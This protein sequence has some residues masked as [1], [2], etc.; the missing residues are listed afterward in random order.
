MTI[1]PIGRHELEVTTANG[2]FI[3]REI[4]GST[5]FNMYDHLN[6]TV[7]GRA[8]HKPTVTLDSDEYV[9]VLS[10]KDTEDTWRKR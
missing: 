7:T 6:L 2:V 1:R 4:D 8:K 10:V 3:V 9:T 5:Q